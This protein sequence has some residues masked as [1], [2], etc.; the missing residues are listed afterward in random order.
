LGK[1]NLKRTDGVQKGLNSIVRLDESREIISKVADARSVKEKE[2]RQNMATLYPV[3]SRY[4][5]G[6]DGCIVLKDSIHPDNERAGLVA[7]ME[8]QGGWPRPPAWMEGKKG[9]EGKEEE[10]ER[11]ETKEKK[12]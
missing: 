12:E 2:V 5:Y 3:L 10:K 4:A 7:I 11:K 6:N 1:I 9:K 8:I